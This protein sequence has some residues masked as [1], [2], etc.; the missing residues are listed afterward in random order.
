MHSEM[1]C[2]LPLESGGSCS[3]FLGRDELSNRRLPSFRD[4]IPFSLWKQAIGS[5]RTR[6]VRYQQGSF[7]TL[8]PS[9]RGRRG[10]SVRFTNA[11]KPAACDRRVLITA[12]PRHDWFSFFSL[13]KMHRAG[14]LLALFPPA[15]S[16]AQMLQSTFPQTVHHRRSNTKFLCNFS[17]CSSAEKSLV[18]HR[19][20]AIG[21]KLNGFL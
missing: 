6:K 11:S 3:L 1:I 17:L 20:L 18:Y 9:N 4:V 14:T 2:S 8:S 19:A 12:P 7:P 5:T 10:K 16:F 21:K 13:Y 15:Q